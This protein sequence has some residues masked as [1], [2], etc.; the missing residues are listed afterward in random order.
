[1]ENCILQE[2][3]STVEIEMDH[4]KG[5]LCDL[6]GIIYETECKKLT[7]AISTPLKY[8]LKRNFL[9]KSIETDPLHDI[10]LAS[11]LDND[12]RAADISKDT[13][14]D[15]VRIY[16]KLADDIGIPNYKELIKIIV[17]RK[18]CNVD[19]HELVSG[20]LKQCRRLHVKPVFL[21]LL[22]DLNL[23]ALVKYKV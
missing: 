18:K 14:N 20:Y 8:V 2:R 17:Y 3:L 1:M 13:Y 23:N 9:N 4:L 11:L 10:L 6:S 5:S 12:Y 22:K 21:E 15:I 16:E 7:L 19:Q